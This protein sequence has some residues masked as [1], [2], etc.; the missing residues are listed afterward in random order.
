VP[1]TSEG[2]VSAAVLHAATEGVDGVLVHTDRAGVRT[3]L[4]DRRL[5]EGESLSVTVTRASMETL[6]FL[7]ADGTTIPAGLT[8]T[9]SCAGVADPNV[10]ASPLA[11]DQVRCAFTA[12]GLISVEGEGLTAAYL[13]V[14]GAEFDVRP[15]G[16]FAP[17]A[18][19]AGV[20]PR[21][22][23]GGGSNSCN[24]LTQSFRSCFPVNCAGTGRQSC[25]STGQWGPCVIPEV[26][27]GRDDNC[28]GTVDE[29]GNAL[30]NDLLSCTR[31]YCGQYFGTTTQCSNVAAPA[32][33]RRGACTRGI[34]N[35]TADTVGPVEA[36]S[37]TSAVV[38]NGCSY[39][40]SD[41]HCENNW[42]RCVCNG[43][44]R[45][46]GTYA[47]GPDGVVGW[48]GLW[49]GGSTTTTLAANQALLDSSQSTCRDR[50]M[51][52]P[53]TTTGPVV[54]AR[55]GGCEG[56][57]D[58]CTLDGFCCEPEVL[59]CRNYRIG[60]VRFTPAGAATGLDTAYANLH[61]QVCT[62][63]G[64]TTATRTLDGVGRTCVTGVPLFTL[65]QLPN[66]CPIDSNPCTEPP[67]CE[68]VNLGTPWVYLRCTEAN[69][70]PG[71][72][73][74]G[75]GATP[76]GA[77]GDP[78]LRTMAPVNTSCYRQHCGGSGTL[79]NGVCATTLNDSIC[80]SELVAT[81]CGG[82]PHCTGTPYT[83]SARAG[84]RNGGGTVFGC[85]RTSS[86]WDAG[87]GQCVAPGTQG[88][89]SSAIDRCRV[90]APELGDGYQALAPTYTPCSSLSA[91]S[92]PCNRCDAAGVCQPTA[93]PQC[94]PGG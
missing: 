54:V 33:C 68:P 36:T 53:L 64:A 71:S 30:C 37:N 78:Y 76:D 20:D 67:L 23:A 22:A 44:A 25:L 75:C 90:C 87:T 69:S 34:C 18:E 31:D 45:C 10:D 15:A 16:Y 47:S 2:R 46:Q 3:L 91:G 49:L 59:Q 19:R 43:R 70:P 62:A 12:E 35:G 88:P 11:S 65:P 84:A 83:A 28:N 21:I 29:S 63:V 39:T 57:G 79:G 82:T 8:E 5:A 4:I 26:C 51:F 61:N 60:K 86:C 93:I 94:G 48:N 81:W 13:A 73:R 77:T 66:A 72:F 42:D 1:T 56:D 85:T 24:P 89:Y 14:A 50:T 55:N 40:E 17:R 32:V 6:G 38:A 27:N 74:P 92:I 7:G 9:V 58:P 52:E 41:M 80:S